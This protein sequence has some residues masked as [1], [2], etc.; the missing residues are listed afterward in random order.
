MII[1]VKIDR[2]VQDNFNLSIAINNKLVF[3]LIRGLSKDGNEEG[4]QSIKQFDYK[5]QNSMHKLCRTLLDFVQIMQL[6][7]NFVL[8][9]KHS[10]IAY[11]LRNFC[12]RSF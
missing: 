4:G 2:H 3:A 8:V 12:K 6:C 10:Q 7:T 1:F 9:K 11:K 5:E